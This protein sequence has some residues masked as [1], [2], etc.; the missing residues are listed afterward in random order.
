MTLC[1]LFLAKIHACS[2]RYG[3]LSWYKYWYRAC[4]SVGRHLSNLH[5][6][7]LWARSKTTPSRLARQP[8]AQVSLAL[9][10]QLPVGLLWPAEIF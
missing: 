9:Q 8:L 2:S 1:I 5:H 10:Y 3:I 6:K 4:T 7:S